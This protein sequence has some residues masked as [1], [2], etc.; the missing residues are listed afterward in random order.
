MDIFAG[1]RTPLRVRALRMLVEERLRQLSLQA[2]QGDVQ[3]SIL[4]ALQSMGKGNARIPS[5]S[6]MVEKA[7][8]KGNGK[9]GR[10]DLSNAETIAR[11]EQMMEMFSAG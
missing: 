9:R 5:Y 10:R 8:K 2:Y 1:C 3:W 4:R 7:Y 11:V 6:D